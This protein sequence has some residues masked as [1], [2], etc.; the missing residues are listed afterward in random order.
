[1][2]AT[3][4]APARATKSKT[5]A[6]VIGSMGAALALFT[7][8]PAEESGRKVQ[9]SARPDG[10][11][12][13]KHLSGKQYLDAYLDIVNVPTACDGITRGIKMG[14]RYTP[15]QCTMLLER[16]LVDHAQGVIDCVPTLYGR[17]GQAIA[18]VSLA[19]NIGVRR[20]C[21]STA[22]RLFRARQ[23][24]AACDAMPAWNRAGGRVVPGLV[25]RRAREHAL[26]VKDLS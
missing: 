10:S 17:E 18:A 1:M 25:A 4:S 12:V 19:Y 7:L 23:W 8:I 9:A 2:D 26:C 3:P 22:A 11:V 21:G 13:L 5:L 6:G 15:A 16:E 24:R 20:F 14:Q